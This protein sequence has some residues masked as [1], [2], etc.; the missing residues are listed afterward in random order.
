MLPSDDVDP[1][2]LRSI[3]QFVKTYLHHQVKKALSL[4]TYADDDHK[5]SAFSKA[6]HAREAALK[7]L[8]N[9][10]VPL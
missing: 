10:S 1:N 8:E 7:K 5:E 2:Y 9:V 3:K 6:N 4:F